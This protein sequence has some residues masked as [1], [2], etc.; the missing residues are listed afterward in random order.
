VEEVA[1]QLSN[2]ITLQSTLIAGESVLLLAILLIL[3]LKTSPPRNL[4]NIANG[5]VIAGWQRVNFP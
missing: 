2:L 5:Q 4:K 1:P 3:K